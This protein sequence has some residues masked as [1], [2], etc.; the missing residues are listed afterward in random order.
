M[1]QREIT[2]G[3]QAK[4]KKHPALSGMGW[5]PVETKAGSVVLQG[6]GLFQ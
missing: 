4:M 6:R 2:T 5:L 1:G 3:Q